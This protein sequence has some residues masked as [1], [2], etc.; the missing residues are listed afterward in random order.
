M[1]E[2]AMR[3]YSNDFPY[4]AKEK[5]ICVYPLYIDSLKSLSKGRKIP[6]E[7]AVDSP[8]KNEIQMVLQDIGLDHI[9][10]NKAHPKDLDCWEPNS[11]TRFRVR[12][13]NDDG[14]PINNDYSSRIA[15]L[16]YLGSTIPKLKVRSA[17]ASATPE[18]IKPKKDNK[19]GKRR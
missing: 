10:E 2:A 11:R 1:A 4:S 18:S 14:S 17:T 19:K 12:L 8:K 13:F 6:K 9:C 5:W 16:K 3:P 7:F 15:L